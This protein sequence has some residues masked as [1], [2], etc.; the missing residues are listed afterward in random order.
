[1]VRLVMLDVN[2]TLF[3]LEPVADR[4]RSVGLEGQFELWFTRILR[5]GFA[6]T[7]AGSRCEF[8]DLARHHLTSML[9]QRGLDASDHV[10]DEVIAGFQV[11][12]AHPDVGDGLRAL[13]DAGVTAVT[14]TVGSADITRSFLE[15]EGL[16]DLVATVYDAEATGWWKPSPR[17]YQHVLD[18]HGVLAEHA[19]L[20]A[21]HPWDVMGA[22]EAGM[23]GAWLDRTGERYPDV[24]PAPTVT[25]ASL[26]AIVAQLV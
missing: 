25:A 5:D 23:V 18:E 8:A 9:E 19:A 21:V 16:A 7:A 22:Q 11:V 3:S 2:E 10:V 26:P 14:L 12:A 13:R 20:V 6:A 24:F 15:R 4:M 17:A 1:M